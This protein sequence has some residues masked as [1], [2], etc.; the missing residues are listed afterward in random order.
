MNVIVTI[1]GKEAIPVRAIP[2]LTDWEVLSPDECANAFAGA[3]HA[4]PHLEGL[5]TFRLNADGRHEAI[6]PRWW[7]N[8]IVRALDACSERIT[9]G[10]AS[11]EVGYQQWR[12]EALVL[13]PA[14][15]FVWRESFEAAYQHEYG[16]DSLRVR[17]SEQAYQ[18]ETYD[19][20][21]NPEHGP[22]KDWR[23]LVLEGFKS[24]EDAGGEKLNQMLEWP[25]APREVLTGQEAAEHEAAWMDATLDAAMFFA[26]PHVTPV[27]AAMLLCRLNPQNEAEKDAE[28]C[29]TDCT[30]PED[31]KRLRTLFNSVDKARPAN[32]SLL[33]WMETADELKCKFHPW[34]WRY[35]KQRELNAPSEPATDTVLP[36]L[37]VTDSASNA[38]VVTP[39]PVATGDVAYAF[40]GLRGW[41]EKAWKDTLGSPPMWLD[42]CIAIR[43]QRGVRE[44]HWNPVLIGAALVHNG[45]AKQNNI[46][47]RFQ[48]KPQLKDWL[49]AWKTYEADNFDTQ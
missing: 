44:N 41:N 35:V 39:P 24:N 40:D 11:H 5:P 13:L 28:N 4:V 3:E 12:Q 25:N 43:G 23:E 16:P 21:F 47:A 18:A 17:F 22:C 34:A 7:A 9:A 31:F 42:A 14:G 2:L 48:T 30:K 10:Q 20:N 49:E 46:R 45:H 15:V 1:E 33:D 27:Q 37:T 38:P 32:R 6:S 29:N 8:W 26:L 36:A 19:L